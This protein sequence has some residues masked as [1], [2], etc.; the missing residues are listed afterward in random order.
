M[1]KISKKDLIL[2]IIAKNIVSGKESPKKQMYIVGDS[3]LFITVQCN[4]FGKVLSAFCRNGEEID[5][6]DK[7]E[8]AVAISKACKAK[9]VSYNNQK[10]K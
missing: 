9:L 4:D 10:I 3:T 6:F 1:E 8:D 2:G 5:K 7:A